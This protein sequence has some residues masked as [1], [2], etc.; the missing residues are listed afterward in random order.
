MSPC[1]RHLEWK[2][3]RRKRYV[4][5]H[6]ASRMAD[7]EQRKIKQDLPESQCQGKCE[8]FFTKYKAFHFLCGMKKGLVI[9]LTPSSVISMI[10]ASK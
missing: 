4:T 5:L 9:V 2:I 3:H 8:L 7:T 6:E 10:E 1:V